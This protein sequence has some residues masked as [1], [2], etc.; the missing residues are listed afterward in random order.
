VDSANFNTASQQ[1][2]FEQARLTI[3][4][5]FD[6]V[7]LR[8]ARDNLVRQG[9]N[10]RMRRAHVLAAIRRLVTKVGCEEVTVRGIAEAS[11]YAVQT[12]Y[13]L[14]GPRDEA[15][16]DAISEYSI[17]VGRAAS[18]APEDPSTILAIVNGWLE[19]ISLTPEFV[20]QSNLVF[21]TSS[22]NIYYRWRDRQVQGLYNLL[23]KQKAA[24]IIK[25]DV[26]CKLLAERVG[27]F[28]SAMI[29]EWSDRPF[30]L[31]ALREKLCAG[32]A[33]MLADSVTPEHAHRLPDWRAAIRTPL[34]AHGALA[35][36]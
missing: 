26:D 18:R 35:A 16:S 36:R 11:G 27:L 13:N 4:A 32:I 29:I 20:R 9:A 22:R 2:S 15:I 5:P 23:R 12:I 10:Q 34:V 33:N 17:F 25:S 8:A 14:V 30:A 24:G 19:A 21:F 6:P 7:P 1:Q 31:D 28:A 3:C